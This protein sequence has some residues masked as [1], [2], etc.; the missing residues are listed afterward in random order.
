MSDNMSP[1]HKRGEHL[2]VNS[3]QINLQEHYSAQ[4]GVVNSQTT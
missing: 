1:E 3:M 2:L 4:S